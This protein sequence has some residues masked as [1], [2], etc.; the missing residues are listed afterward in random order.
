MLTGVVVVMR[1]L[2]PFNSSGSSSC[3]SRISCSS[4]NFDS[5]SSK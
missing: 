4:I 2:V 5:G 3:N 1:V